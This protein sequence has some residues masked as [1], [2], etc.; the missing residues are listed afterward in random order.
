M[1][2]RLKRERGQGLVEYSLIL[3]LIAV[4]LVLIVGVVGRRVGND[5]SNVSS[6]LGT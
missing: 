3:I 6:G 2:S 5:F 4:V 1:G